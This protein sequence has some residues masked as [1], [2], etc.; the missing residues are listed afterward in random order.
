MA[1]KVALS[2]ARDAFKTRDSKT[3]L[4]MY[5]V[6]DIMQESRLNRIG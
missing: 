5:E 4:K 3:L 2:C 1:G 6:F